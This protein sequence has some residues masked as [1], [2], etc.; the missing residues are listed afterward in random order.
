MSCQSE[1]EEWE[2]L[3]VSNI[4][5]LP[6]ALREVVSEAE[7]VLETSEET[8]AE[9][10]E[11]SEEISMETIAEIPAETSEEKHEESLVETPEETIEEILVESLVESPAVTLVMAERTECHRRMGEGTRQGSTRRAEEGGS[12]IE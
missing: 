6:W 9:T 10:P 4:C 1:E 5:L 7:E 8:L 11:T 3:L 2:D 12:T